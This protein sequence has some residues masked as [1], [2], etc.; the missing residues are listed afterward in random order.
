VGRCLLE[1]LR[2][3]IDRGLWGS[4]STSQWLS[5]LAL[6]VFAA[7]YLHAIP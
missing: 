6:L 2:G 7:F 4:F 1:F 5:L 3:D